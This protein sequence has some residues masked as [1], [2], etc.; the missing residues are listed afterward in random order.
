M[1]ER[2]AKTKPQDV[3]SPC[4]RMRER[5]STRE[6]AHLCVAE[7]HVTERAGIRSFERSNLVILLNQCSLCHA[8]RTC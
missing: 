1:G 8:A 2:T 6:I 7:L 4:V 3:K 5:V